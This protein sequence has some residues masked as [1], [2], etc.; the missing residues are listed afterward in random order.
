MIP[1]YNSTKD[2]CDGC[3]QEFDDYL[4]ERVTEHPPL[5]YLCPEC[6]K[7]REEDEKK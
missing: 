4:L 3:D 7:K 5:V 2:K 1:L 6:R